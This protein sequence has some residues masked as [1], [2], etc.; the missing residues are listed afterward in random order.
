[1]KASAKDHA[2]IVCLLGNKIKH[3]KEGNC[4][5][6]QPY[7]KRNQPHADGIQPYHKP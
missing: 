7:N 6:I 2:E 4:D 3:L 5:G 1:M